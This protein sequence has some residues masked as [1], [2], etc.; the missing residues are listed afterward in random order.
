MLFRSGLQ[1]LGPAD[2]AYS[3]LLWAIAAF[4]MCATALRL[5]RFNAEVRSA[6][7]EDHLYFRGMPSPGAGGAVASLIL[8]HQHLLFTRPGIEDHSLAFARTAALG[9][10]LVTL[11]VAFAMISNIRYSHFA[12]RILR[13]RRGF[14]SLLRVVIPVLLFFWWPAEALAAGFVLYAL[15][16]PILSLLHREKPLLA[17]RAHESNSHHD[18]R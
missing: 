1:I 14:R 12:N 4:Y 17:A 18:H 13:A 7:E 15:S 5:A 2:S 8:L 6:K 9:I 16:G 3:K 11:I 10:P